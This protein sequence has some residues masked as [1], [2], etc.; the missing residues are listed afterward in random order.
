MSQ[1]M[2]VWSLETVFINIE[3]SL[4]NW[5]K[6]I[7]KQE[8][9]L[10]VC[11]QYLGTNTNFSNFWIEQNFKVRAGGPGIER[12]DNRLEIFIFFRFSGEYSPQFFKGGDV[13]STL[14]MRG[15]VPLDL[16]GDVPP[17]PTHKSP[18]YSIDKYS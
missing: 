7:E 16:Q 3:N 17:I 5:R 10:F 11:C 6:T 15:D 9:T 14:L 1:L 18:L 13:P 12:E 8:F 4:R 2:R